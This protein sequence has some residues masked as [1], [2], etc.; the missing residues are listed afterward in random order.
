VRP[1][2]AEFSINQPFGSYA[3]GGVNPNQFGSEV[4]QLVYQYGNYQPYGHAGCD[5]AC[6]VGTPVHA[7]A[8]G[9]V[10]WADWGTNLPGDDTDAGYRQRWYLYKTFPG[11]VTVI[12]HDGWVSVYAHLS[13]APLNPGDRV[14]E[15]QQIALSGNTRSPGVSLGAHLHVEALVDTSYTTGN[16]LI[17]GRTN[18]EPYFG[19]IAAQGTITPLSEEDDMPYTP[20]EMRAFAKAGFDAWAKEERIFAGS[21]NLVDQLNQTRTE[22]GDGVRAAKAVPG[23]V[24][25]APVRNVLTGKDTTLATELGWLPANF[26]NVPANVLNA[27]FKLADGT[28]TNLAGILSAI[29]A[30][31]VT[32]GAPADPLA[33]VHA[34]RDQLNK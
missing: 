2:S 6:P 21:L 16:G 5:I 18:P 15:G 8:A 32:G 24:L 25:N 12:Q 31:P 22:V 34:L 28:V 1:V 13:D 26:A 4:E 14:T 33:V 9:T 7:I 20:D 19:G 3:T 17:Y 27:Q 23:A 30:Q 29:H 10:L 11:I